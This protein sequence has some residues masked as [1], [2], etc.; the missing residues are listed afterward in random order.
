[1][2]SSLL[3]LG[4]P[5]NQEALK[6]EHP[7]CSRFVLGVKVGHRFE[8][9]PS[10][11]IEP[12]VTHMAGECSGA[13]FTDRN[14]CLE[15]PQPESLNIVTLFVPFLALSEPRGQLE[16]AL[17]YCLPS[18]SSSPGLTLGQIAHNE[19]C[20]LKTAGC[21]V[22]VAGSYVLSHCA[23]S[24]CAK[25]RKAAFADWELLPFPLS[26]NCIP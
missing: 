8:C 22:S 14:V 13:L 10:Y 1:M 2:S 15:R 11:V 6:E 7:A 20:F 24:L 19:T 9:R 5:S 25:E 3:L 12:F 16:S 23:W 4:S 17:W 21:G 26:S 18:G